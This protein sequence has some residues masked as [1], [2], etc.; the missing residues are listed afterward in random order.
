[1]CFFFANK[2]SI[3]QAFIQ[4]LN[5]ILTVSWGQVQKCLST[6]L[7]DASQN[8]VVDVGSSQ[9]RSRNPKY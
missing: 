7:I 5:A 4:A 2:R 3:L 6:N 1:M 8:E 9:S